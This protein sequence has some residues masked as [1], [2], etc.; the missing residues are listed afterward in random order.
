MTTAPGSGATADIL[1][2]IRRDFAIG[3][4]KLKPSR[5][6]LIALA[7]DFRHVHVID[8]AQ[9]SSLVN[10]RRVVAARF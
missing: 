5:V 6:A 10:M 9:P 4:A 8:A 7:Y 1:V 3:P 2:R